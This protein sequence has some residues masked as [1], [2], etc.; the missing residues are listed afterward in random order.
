MS[1]A[2]FSLMQRLARL[3]S[4]LNDEEAKDS[5]GEDAFLSGLRYGRLGRVVVCGVPCFG[6]EH[7]P[8][9]TPLVVRRGL[10][11]SLPAMWRIPHAEAEL[12]RQ[13]LQ[14]LRREGRVAGPRLLADRF[15]VLRAGSIAFGRDS[16]IRARGR[17]PGPPEPARGIGGRGFGAWERKLCSRERMACSRGRMP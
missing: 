13:V 16:R 8:C 6:V 3:Y 2:A 12:D 15:A 10:G 4:C 5:Q 9:R 14:A 1:D 11:E 17:A 7:Q